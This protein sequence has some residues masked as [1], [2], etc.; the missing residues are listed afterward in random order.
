MASNFKQ[1]RLLSESY[2]MSR[3]LGLVN[4]QNLGL[5]SNRPETAK[6]ME[7]NMKFDMKHM[8]GN[9][10]DDEDDEMMMKR[11]GDEDIGDDDGDDLDVGDDNDLEKASDM[12]GDEGDDMGDDDDDDD[13]D[14]DE[15]DGDEE[16]SGDE[17]DGYDDE[18]GDELSGLEKKHPPMGR[19]H[20][21]AAFMARH[22]NE[23][24]KSPP[25]A[26]KKDDEKPKKKVKGKKEDKKDTKKKMPWMKDEKEDKGEKKSMKS[27]KG[28]CKKCSADMPVKES[29]VPDRMDRKEFA[30]RIAEQYGLPGKNFNGVID[31][32]MLIAN[33]DS[34]PGPGDVG[35]A[36]QTR[37]GELNQ[38]ALA[39]SVQLL[40]K[41]VERLERK[42][43]KMF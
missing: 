31:E 11:S 4:P 1:H 19:A 26:N 27:G 41:K 2:G 6:E 33:K 21:S 5:A 7:E 17:D 32:D 36:P 18:D 42:I 37:V 23:G 39:E 3:N 15:G 10:H 20:D 24:K 35:Y 12:D 40:I 30:R 13:D 28:D 22:M 25:W 29:K 38:K 8:K 34:E 9:R 16:M 14:G 43:N